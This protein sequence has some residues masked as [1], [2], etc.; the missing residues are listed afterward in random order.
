MINP[1]QNQDVVLCDTSPIITLCTFKIS[2][3]H[4]IDD[5]ISITK[6]HVTLAVVTIVASELTANPSH[7][8]SAI[9]NRLLRSEDIRTLPVPSLPE[10][11]VVDL[12]TKLGQGERDT[13]RLGM[14]IPSATVM[15]DDYLAY[16]VAERFGLKSVLLLD[17]I[18]SLTTRGLLTRERS[19]EVINSIRLRYSMAFVDHTLYKVSQIEP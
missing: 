5:L 12:Y 2:G 8:D 1:A 9:A 14:T 6:G 10:N 3:K 7:T 4:I 15:F 11:S 18:V 13:I 17:F 16:V 19:I